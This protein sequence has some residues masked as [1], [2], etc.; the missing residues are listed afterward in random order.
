MRLYIHDETT[1]PVQ[2]GINAALT[3]S[4]PTE[5]MPMRPASYVL[6]LTG[7]LLASLQLATEPSGGKT[8]QEGS[9]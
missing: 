2:L 8:Y 6:Y 9:E 4:R 7:F 5:P 1:N 3:G